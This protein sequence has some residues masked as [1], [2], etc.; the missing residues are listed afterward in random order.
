MSVNMHIFVVKE[1]L[2][3]CYA[4]SGGR[5]RAPVGKRFSAQGMG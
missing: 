5:G 3:E 2:C 4:G 1:L